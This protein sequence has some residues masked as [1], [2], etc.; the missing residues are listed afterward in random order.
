MTEQSPLIAQV[1]K[2]KAGQ[3]KREAAELTRLV[4][5][6]RVVYD[7][8]QAEVDA[9]LAKIALQPG[10][11]PGQVQRMSR[12]KQLLEEIEQEVQRYSAYV[13]VELHTVSRAAITQGERDARVL[14]E[15]AT[16]GQVT[17]AELR[18]LN[19]EVITQ[20]TG[21]LDPKG[22]LWKKLDGIDKWTSEQVGQAI[23]E[24][25][26]LGQNP[27]TIA[28]AITKSMGMGLTQSMQMM[29]TVQL[30]SYRE[31]NRASYV[32]NNNIVTGWVWMATLDTTV[33]ASCVAMHGTEH[34]LSE[35]LNDHHNGRCA[36]VPITVLGGN[37]VEQNGDE[38]F[39]SLNEEQQKAILGPGKLDAWQ[40]GKFEL[41]DIPTTYADDVYGPMRT[42]KTL[43]ELL[44]DDPN[45]TA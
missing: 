22:E 23:L 37:P 15:L 25:I 7:R 43:Q 26:G 13:N 6:Y 5:A 4:D 32:A 10:A 30:W 24:G 27:R 21:F 14:A 3:A 33:C 34:E 36:M 18:A 44:G 38:W 9:L 11:T 29:R 40:N 42:E 20:L 41:A 16:D 39:R 8:T 35:P 31:A 2:F 17:F 12:Y 28:A 19:P 1:E 45:Q